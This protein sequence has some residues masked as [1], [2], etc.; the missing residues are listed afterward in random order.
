MNAEALWYSMY[1]GDGDPP[2]CKRWSRMPMGV[3]W[4]LTI[5][6]AI[7]WSIGQAGS[8]PT[9]ISKTHERYWYWPHP[10]SDTGWWMI[11]HRVEVRIKRLYTDARA[12]AFYR[13]AS[14]SP[15][16]VANV[17]RHWKKS[18]AWYRHVWG[19]GPRTAPPVLLPLR[20]RRADQRMLKTHERATE[21]RRQLL[22]TPVPE[23]GG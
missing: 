4:D 17:L 16:D 18:G 9:Y 14:V 3:Q 21:R 12:E 15:E 23:E 1:D 11:P 10:L 5:D 2:K 13:R 20:Q 22:A 6:L 8:R 7:D 19:I